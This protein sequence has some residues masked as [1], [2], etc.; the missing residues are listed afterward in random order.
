MNR[1]INKI[2]LISPPYTLMKG[3]INR[4]VPPLGLAYIG[5]V[6]EKNNY[7]VKI[8]DAALEGFG[9]Q[10]KINENHYRH[11]LTPFQLKQQ[12]QE[13]NPDIVGVSCLFSPQ[14]HN[15]QMVCKSAKEVSPNILT[16][17]GGEHPSVFSKEILGNNQTVD[18]VVIGEGE[19]TV[20]ELIKCIESGKDYSSIDGLSFRSNNEVIVNPKTRFITD[21]DAVPLPARHLLNMDK[22]FDINLP[23]ATTPLKKP[24]TSMIT[25]RGCSGHCIFCAT[26][27]HWGNRYR[28]RSPENVL[29][30][31]KFLTDTYKIKELHFLD[32]NLTLNKKRAL[33]IFRKLKDMNLDLKWCT[34]QGVATWTLDE[35]LLTAMKECG[36]YELT[37]AIESGDENV[38]KNI[39]RKPGNIEHT[40]KV[41]KIMKKLNI[42]T[43]AFFVSGFPGETK[44]QI[45]KTFRLADEL[46]LDHAMFL[47]ATPLPGTELYDICKEKNYLD[48]NY[49]YNN[50][51]YAACYIN[52]KDFSSS[53]IDKMVSRKY[54]TYHFNILFRNPKVFFKRY[55]WFFLKNPVFMTGFLKYIFFMIR[56]K[57]FSREV[58]V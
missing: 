51:E 22:Y 5:A 6:L 14:F 34:P 17:I 18:F 30:E 32:D 13:F 33:E 55:V 23:Q 27:K 15:L 21:L 39:I 37:L 49:N 3:R 11:G 50:I 26:T 41:V 4:A 43:S 7:H 19:Q 38:L 2:L 47:I 35:E 20:L 58:K 24:N 42:S 40:K 44:E 54:V 52:T 25:S 1:K 29:Q 16:M 45:E 8:V 56:G 36:C 10:E 46:E 12:I 28:A 57:I 9:T 48:S 53:E 31:I